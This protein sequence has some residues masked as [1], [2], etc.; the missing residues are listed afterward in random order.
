MIKA[1][2]NGD[3]SPRSHPRLPVV[4][5]DVGAAARDA[6]AAGAGMVHVHPRD[7]SGHESLAPIDVVATVA[8]IRA[9]SPGTRISVTTRDGIARDT[10]QKLALVTQWPAPADGG[11]DCA[12]VNW[13]EAGAIDI[14]QALRDKGIGVEA[15]LWTPQAATT[16]VS[17]NWPWQVERV[18]VEV[19]PGVT[20]GSEGPWAAERVIAA[21]G[22]IPP[23]MLVH[24][25]QAWAW[26]VLRWAQASGYDVRIGLEDTL[27]LPTGREAHDNA[28]L[29]AE[30][31]RSDSRAPAQWPIPDPF[32]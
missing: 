5:D 17:T 24:G 23:R 31:A 2:L 16:F 12:S 22:M 27:V 19:I 25:E 15:G 21:V 26:P 28:E 3:R 18:L 9:A 10:H 29:V 30:A 11:P 8:A 32:G 13:H 6:M 20:P 1:C 7:P 4:P 14:G